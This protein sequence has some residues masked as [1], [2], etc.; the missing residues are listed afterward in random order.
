MRLKDTFITHDSQEGQILIDVSNSFAGLLRS[1]QTAAFIIDCL[2]KDT[3][4]EQLVDRLY[5]RYD[6]SR[7]V[8]EHDTEEILEKLRKIGAL[9]E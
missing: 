6:A 1:N 8:I 2:G 9:E 5:E 7:D 4:K 3:T